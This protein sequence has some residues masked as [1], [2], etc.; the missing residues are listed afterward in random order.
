MNAAFLIAQRL[1]AVAS[2]HPNISEWG[3]SFISCAIRKETWS[4]G[5]FKDDYVFF[6]AHVL[7][8]LWPNGDADFA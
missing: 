6:A 2:H 7:K 4:V 1:Y 3:L 5:L 8:Y